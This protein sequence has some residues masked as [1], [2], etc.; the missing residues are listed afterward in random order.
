RGRRLAVGAGYAHHLELT[1]GLAVEARGDRSHRGAH[2]VDH[3]LRHA[4]AQRPLADER[5]RAA[6]DGVEREV[7]PVRTEPGHAEEE[8]ALLNV[9]A[10]KRERGDLDAR[11]PTACE[12]AEIHLRAGYRGRRKGLLRRNA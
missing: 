4:E 1:R 9:V 2:V 11:S 8:R 5:G 12:L 6:G 7:M 10:R 3:D